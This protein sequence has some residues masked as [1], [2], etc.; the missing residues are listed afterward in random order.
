MPDHDP[1]TPPPTSAAPTVHCRTLCLWL[2]AFAALSVLVAALGAVA[3]TW[4]ITDTTRALANDLADRFE[5]TLNLRPEI[6]VDGHVL[7]EAKAT[8]LELATTSRTFVVRHRW[9]Q[10]WLHST[11]TIEIEAPFTAKAG[12][13]LGRTPL[14]LGIDPHTRI[15]TADFPKPE[16]L[17]LEMGDVRVMGEGNGLWNRIT[18]HDREEALRDLKALARKTALETS[19]L[20][21]AALEAEKRIR[22]LIEEEVRSEK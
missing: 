1:L 6:R 16:L 10:T 4:R 19:L 7:L 22:E 12:L 3:L 20:A 2:L 18:V 11:K 21:E 14:R 8:I 13:N 15:V 9:E 17:S 5:R